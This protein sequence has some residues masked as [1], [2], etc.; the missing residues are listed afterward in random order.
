[1]SV[2]SRIRTSR[3][4]RSKTRSTTSIPTPTVTACNFISRARVVASDRLAGAGCWCRNQIRRGASHR[5]R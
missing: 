1:V 2:M 3:G 4:R 5:A